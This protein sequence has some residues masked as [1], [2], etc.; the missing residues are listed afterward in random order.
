VH[1]AEEAA[2]VFLR[3]AEH[4]RRLARYRGAATRRSPHPRGARLGNK[5]RRCA[6]PPG[7]RGERKWQHGEAIL[8]PHPGK[9]LQ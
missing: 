1:A 2:D 4:A 7:R 8:S 9:H 5:E 6:R 3:R